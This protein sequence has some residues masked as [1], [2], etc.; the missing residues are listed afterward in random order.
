[1]PTRYYLCPYDTAIRAGVRVRV[2]AMVRHLPRLPRDDGATWE[3]AET[4]GNHCL[5]KVSATVAVLTT[6]EDDAD[7]LRIPASGEVRSGRRAALLAKLTALGFQSTEI[8]SADWDASRLLALL[9]S[10]SGGVEADGAGGFRTTNRRLQ[11]PKPLA[12][13]ERRLPN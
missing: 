12:V 6:V 5:V 2:P 4:L 3:E 7:F 13:L 8:L 9:A 11:P 1:M 10:T